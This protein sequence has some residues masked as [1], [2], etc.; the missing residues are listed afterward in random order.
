MPLSD[1]FWSDEETALAALLASLYLQTLA[2][3]VAGGEALLPA[4]F[5]N[6]VDEA[7][8][9][10]ASTAQFQLFRDETLADIM[11][12]TR[13][14][15]DA[16]YD[17]WL[18]NDGENIALLAAMIAPLFSDAR[19]ESIAVTETTRAFSAG[20]ALLWSVLGFV[21][22]Y[23]WNTQ[24]DE[25]VCPLCGPLDG[26]IYLITSSVKPPRHPNCRCWISPVLP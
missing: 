21:S 7:S 3:G 13:E 2:Q 12:T 6:L 9:G 8:V 22:A 24:R 18:A 4:E 25:R 14:G 11:A 10:A 16:I 20:N 26:R 17:D 23:R 15:V 5:Q 1:E 19:A